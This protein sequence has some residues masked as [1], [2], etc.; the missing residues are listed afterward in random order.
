[1]SGSGLATRFERFAQIVLP[2]REAPR[3]KGGSEGKTKRAGMRPSS[4]PSFLS[5]A[6]TTRHGR[7]LPNP[8][9]EWPHTESGEESARKPETL[10]N[11]RYSGRAN[12][13]PEARMPDF[14]AKPIPRALPA[15]LKATGCVTLR[16]EKIKAQRAHCTGA[17]H[18]IRLPPQRLGFTCIAPP[19][20][21]ERCDNA[22]TTRAA[23]GGAKTTGGGCQSRFASTGGF[24]PVTD[25]AK[26]LVCI[27]VYRRG[28]PLSCAKTR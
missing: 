27:T 4:A 20:K 14:S 18:A 8:Q 9:R 28:A 1:M 25:A 5:P 21:Q 15:P 3:S 12:R 26:A 11:P 23:H 22:K 10:V 17:A 19:A 24:E 2:Y 6:A 13:F 16:T 7:G